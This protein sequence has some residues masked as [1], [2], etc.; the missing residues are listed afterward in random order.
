MRLNRCLEA[1]IHETI[2]IHFKVMKLESGR[3]ATTLWIVNEDGGYTEI[4]CFSAKALIPQENDNL[5]MN[6]SLEDFLGK[7]DA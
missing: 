1:A 3:H 4:V 5:L 7:D 2:G 6:I